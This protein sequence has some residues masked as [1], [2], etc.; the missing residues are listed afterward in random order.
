MTARQRPAKSISPPLDDL[1][2]YCVAEILAGGEE[3]TFE[4]LVYECFT[5]FPESFGL[6]RYPE[7]PDS[8]RVNK[9][10]L[11]CRTDRGWLVGTVQEGFRLTP[12]G[13]AI[14]GIVSN[15]LADGAAQPTARASGARTRERYEA[16]LRTIRSDELFRAFEQ[17]GTVDASEMELRR[18]LGATLETPKRVLRQN[19]HAYRSAAEA[20]SDESA[21]EFL[22]ACENIVAT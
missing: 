4:R 5:K 19:L 2:I 20:Y 18:L 10:W 14:A 15:R 11:R 6:S 1:V 12:A 9:S 7:W 17:T 16:L 3:C 22:L 8:A 21:L 13:E